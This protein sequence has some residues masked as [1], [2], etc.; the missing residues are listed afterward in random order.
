[1][2]S[3]DPQ[4]LY[5]LYAVSNHYGTL[6]GGHYTAFARN[7]RETEQQWF[8]FDD[9][10]VSEIE[11]ARVCS[12][13]AYV[14]FYR[15]ADTDQSRWTSLSFEEADGK[16][17]EIAA[18][19]AAENGEKTEHS[20][21]SSSSSERSS[22]EEEA[23]A[24]T[25]QTH[26]E[27]EEGHEEEEEEHNSE[28]EEEE[29]ESLLENGSTHTKEEEEE[30]D[31]AEAESEETKICETDSAEGELYRELSKGAELMLLAQ[32]DRGEEEL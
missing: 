24:S 16:R 20:S 14:L 25:L 19:I 7:H 11:A 27:E 31:P 2:S 10:S 6:G 22:D 21:S 30:E 5:H 4:P 1:M 8:K 26:K 23:S 15:R 9:S 12:S 29:E 17:K 3:E 13:A 32:E 18:E 28:E